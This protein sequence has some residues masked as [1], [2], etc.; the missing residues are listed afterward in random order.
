M[1]YIYLNT[2][3]SL[4][5]SS[6]EQSII[7]KSILTNNI[8]VNAVAGSGKTTTAI[9]I[10]KEYPKHNI[11]LLTYNSRLKTET[12][13]RIKDLGIQN[14]IA[15]NYHAF[16]RAFYT[17]EC[18]N[19]TQMKAC[20]DKI[21]KKEFK[22]DLIIIDEAQ[23]ITPLYYKLICKII[24]DNIV[25]NPHLMLV[26][27][28][29]QSLYEYQ[30]SDYRFLTQA[31]KIFADLSTYP[32]IRCELNTSYR[33]SP[34]I[35]DFIN[36]CFV[37]DSA[38]DM[39]NALSNANDPYKFQI[40]SGK[41]P[42]GIKPQYHI[43]EFSVQK[44]YCELLRI[45]KKGYKPDDIFVLG[46][47]VIS[48][49]KESP[50]P[51]CKFENMVKTELATKHIPIFAPSN[52]DEVI[53]DN[54]MNGKLVFSTFHQAKGL[55]RKVVFII[56]FDESQFRFYLKDEP[57]EFC[58]NTVYVGMTRASKELIMFHGNN[59]PYYQ[60]LSQTN[61]P[62]YTDIHLRRMKITP[63]K[64]YI[65]KDTSVSQLLKHQNEET[66]NECVKLLTI[67][68]VRE[69]NDM[70]TIPHTINVGE[71]YE[72]VSDIT[73]TMIPL[74]YEIKVSGKSNLLSEHIHH[75]D[76]SLMNAAKDIINA[77]IRE[78][79]SHDL[80]YLTTF[81]MTEGNYIYKRTQIDNFGWVSDTNLEMAMERLD[82]I[83]LDPLGKFEV[84]CSF[85]D[86]NKIGNK[87]GTLRGRI[88]FISPDTL[89][90]FK[91]VAK[92]RPEH[93][94]QL[95]LYMLMVSSADRMVGDEIEFYKEGEELS[96]R[97]VISVIT[98]QNGIITKITKKYTTVLCGKK[99]I[100]L[101]G[102]YIIRRK[103]RECYLYN[104]MIDELDKVE[105]DGEG[106]NEIYS[107]LMKKYNPK[108]KSG[109]FIPERYIS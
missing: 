77:R 95:A 32:W 86:S 74:A 4:Y 23:D 36:N 72:P 11:L 51:L 10:A 62:T 24:M 100:R 47:S 20:F 37:F 80:A 59:M 3:M 25:K 33:I 5:P 108:I 102:D 13:A 26:G 45:L 57:R 38:F 53:A 41:E 12:R 93:Y 97:G 83:N 50:T 56:G 1:A 6:L 84:N 76:S 66:L 99:N 58:P 67:T 79:S 68:K 69:A 39:L 85:G 27:D 64:E 42:A 55:E 30:G 103:P 98:P 73:G 104:I 78:L 94:I 46:Q 88:D 9:H 109:E 106:L 35:A 82:S 44:M 14:M 54:I 89:Y 87:V 63:E 29:R 70:I 48:R 40:I 61:L 28:V 90:E 18:I 75:L 101:N 21:P 34:E 7:I 19:E 22:Y 91:C 31:D 52:D 65:I 16:C 105:C 2:S 107:I 71:L 49:N 43:Y 96:N 92:L 15:H 17:D 8:I 60:F 81:A